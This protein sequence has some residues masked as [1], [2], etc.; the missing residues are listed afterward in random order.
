MGRHAAQ[1]FPNAQRAQ[2]YGTPPPADPTA[3]DLAVKEQAET[4]MAGYAGTARTEKQAEPG[5]LPDAPGAPAGPRVELPPL[6]SPP[7]EMIMPDGRVVP[8]ILRV[9]RDSR[10]LAPAPAAPLDGPE[11]GDA[12]A[13]PRA[14][15]CG[16]LPGLPTPKRGRLGRSR[17]ASR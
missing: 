14:L 4:A 5:M 2:H 16:P 12:P 3:A 8:L 7:T 11:W 9:P 13:D 17:K 6:P 1:L 10:L 15:A